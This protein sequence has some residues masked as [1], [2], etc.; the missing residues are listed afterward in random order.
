MPGA[1]A[2]A[3]PPS[4]LP[5]DAVA[6]PMKLFADRVFVT[7]KVN[8]DATAECLI[9][10]GA[11][12][13]LI[14]KAR[15]KLKNLQIT[16]TEQLQGAFVGG[17]AMQK[18]ILP[19]LQI[20]ERV[21]KNIGIGVIDHREG[22]KLGQIDM[23]L[24][25]DFLSRTRFT[26]DYEHERLILWAFRSPLPDAPKGYE[27]ERL[28]LHR[29]PGETLPHVDGV[30][31]GK[32]RVNFLVD[33]GAGGPFFVAF[34]KLSEYGFD[35]S[36][37][38]AGRLRL[39][40]GAKATELIIR[41]V[42]FKRLEFGKVAVEN[43]AGRV[44][45]ASVGVGPLAKSDLQAGNNVLGTPFLKQLAAVHFDM[46]GGCLYFDRKKPEAPGG[47]SADTGKQK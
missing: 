43:L 46:P 31:N 47:A 18:A 24:G 25:M 19:S 12:I 7:A 33:S 28:P 9:D 34:Q 35:D 30:V 1:E 42:V 17:V 26:L 21:H 40:D 8:D 37:A 3:A 27:R 16:G 29:S 14:N 11:E 36:A 10:T 2:P 23:L 13:S 6:I 38:E 5:K 20:G 22:Q 39:N 41:E 4:D 32:T 44:I 45:D 15:V